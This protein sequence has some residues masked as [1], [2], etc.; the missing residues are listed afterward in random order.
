MSTFAGESISA[1][2]TT[3]SLQDSISFD[4]LFFYLLLLF[5]F[6][7]FNISKLHTEGHCQ[8]IEMTI[9]PEIVPERVVIGVLGRFILAGLAKPV[10]LFTD[11]SESSSRR[12]H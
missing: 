4:L 12:F 7:F 2:T 11:D 6:F 9:Q 10:L 8:Q 1:K 5:F 3:R